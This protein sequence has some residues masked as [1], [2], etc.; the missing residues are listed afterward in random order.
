MASLED[1]L[2]KYAINI[3][4]TSNRYTSVGAIK[5][6]ILHHCAICLN[7]DLNCYIDKS[8]ICIHKE[9]MILLDREWQK[10]LDNNEKVSH[11]EINMYK[12]IK[13]SDYLNPVDVQIFLTLLAKKGKTAFLNELLAIDGFKGFK[14]KDYVE[15]LKYLNEKKHICIIREI[16]RNMNVSINVV[17]LALL[18]IYLKYDEKYIK[19]KLEKF[20]K[21]IT[22]DQCTLNNIIEYYKQNIQNLEGLAMI[23]INEMKLCSKRKTQPLLKKQII[24]EDHKERSFK[25]IKVTFMNETENH[26]L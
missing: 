23:K 21:E 18:H 20:Q 24:K 4:K 19:A 15:N 2:Q 16:Y 3:L 26:K 1:I 8:L 11:S 12:M 6:K 5:W 13:F 9:N 17:H 22:Y 7:I 10:L 14:I 25:K